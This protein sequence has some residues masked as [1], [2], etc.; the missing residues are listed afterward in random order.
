M[1]ATSKFQQSMPY[2]LLPVS[3]ELSALY[4]QQ[5]TS[6]SQ[7]SHEFCANCGF[8]LF[9]GQSASRCIRKSGGTKFR[10][11]QCVHCNHKVEISVASGAA[12]VFPSQ[13]QRRR[14]PTTVLPLI[15]IKESVLQPEAVISTSPDVKSSEPRAVEER[16]QNPTSKSRPKK[17]S[18]LQDML[19]RNRKREEKAGSASSSS[20]GLAAFLSGL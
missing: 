10:Q 20:G 12:S 18:A 17:K 13:R 7:D 4:R 11:T 14:H 5:S 8:Y 2:A 1:D 9:D 6:L 15:T 16:S 3:A 19:A